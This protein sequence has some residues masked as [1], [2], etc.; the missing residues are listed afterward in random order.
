MDRSLI[1]SAVSTIADM[2]DLTCHRTKDFGSVVT[3][4]IGFLRPL[5]FVDI[6]AGM[7][8]Y[9]SDTD[10]GGF[11]IAVCTLRHVTTLQCRHMVRHV[12]G[13]WSG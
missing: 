7:R 12:L 2:T 9:S 8:W 11:R 10:D 5:S 4:T 1:Y 6:M 13:P 3:L